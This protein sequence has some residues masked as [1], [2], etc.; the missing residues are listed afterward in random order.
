M[1]T[2][3][4]FFFLVRLFVLFRA[5][6]CVPWSAALVPYCAVLKLCCIQSSYIYNFIAFILSEFFSAGSWYGCLLWPVDWANFSVAIWYE[7]RDTT[8]GLSLIRALCIAR[9]LLNDSLDSLLCIPERCLTESS[10]IKIVSFLII[11][12]NYLVTHPKQEHHNLRQW[13]IKAGRYRLP[14]PSIQQNIG[15]PPP[16]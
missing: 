3:S 11:Q 12:F 2:P 5:W 7:S 9:I 10:H 16:V 15:I 1:D 14:E 6:S 4:F 8:V 13:G